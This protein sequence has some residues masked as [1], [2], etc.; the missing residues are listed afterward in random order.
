MSFFNKLKSRLLKS[1]DKLDKGLDALMEEGE[2]A[3]VAPPETAPEQPPEEKPAAPE[4]KPAEPPRRG[5]LSRLRGEEKPAEPAPG[6][7]EP[8]AAPRF[9]KKRVLDDELLEQLE[10]LLISADLGVD[11]A[12]RVT[13]NLAEGRYGRRVGATEIKRLLAQE[14]ANI[15]EPVARPLP[16]TGQKP[17]VILVVGVNGSG[18]TTTIGK[19]AAQLSG[20]GKSVVVAACDTF[21]AAA[22]EQLQIWG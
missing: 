1:S 6:R 20:A 7:P 21:R 15:L 16:L 3:P 18:K 14:V 4:E 5:L 13:A 2:E 10:D 8:S 9:E 12:L 11:A 22:V 17:Q 19:L